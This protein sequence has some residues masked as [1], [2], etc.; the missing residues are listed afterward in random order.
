[1]S[2]IDFDCIVV[3]AG[4]S[5]C[6][7]AAILSQ[8]K[9]V[10]LLEAGE[11]AS[12]ESFIR[13]SSKATSNY[14]GEF[15]R[16]YWQGE[17]LPI[18]ELGNRMMHYTGGRVLGGSSS[19]NGMQ[20]V[21]GTN[22]DMR[23][24]WRDSERVYNVIEEFIPMERIPHEP[25]DANEEICNA[26]SEGTGFPLIYDY[27]DPSTP[28]GV[29]TQWTLT[30]RNGVRASSDSIFLNE[31]NWGNLTLKTSCTVTRVLFRDK[32]AIGV[33]YLDDGRGKVAYAPEIV[34]S[35][36]I[37]SA[38][39]LLLSGIG[40]REL[41][42]EVGVDL[43]YDNPDVG[44][45]LKNHLYFNLKIKGKIGSKDGIFSGGAFLPD[46]TGKRNYQLILSHSS[47][48]EMN[49]MV[50]MTRLLSEGSV[51][52][53]SSDPLSMES[54]DFN[55]MSHEDDSEMVDYFF[56]EYYGGIEK[57]LSKY[58]YELHS[59][60]DLEK[61]IGETYHFTGT[62]SIGKVVNEYGKVYGVDGLSVIDNSIIPVNVDGNTQ[63]CAYLAG[64]ICGHRKLREMLKL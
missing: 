37:K 58:G 12:E 36:G 20:Y 9:K 4:T 39:I 24:A 1:M 55:Y 28:L 23:G 35:A 5:G 13:N 41:L 46:W 60:N 63:A 3:G 64:W 16:L 14:P 7:V 43:V 32:K 26:L 42:E 53:N 59:F 34:L 10:L 47:K 2:I 25:S 54:V 21:R 62:C 57:S 17:S 61:E 18:K 22:F 38:K 31:A 52:L 6:E 56:S 40:D 19:I 8:E 50:I 48:D 27:N 15:S 11:D 29:F 51:K 44:K 49:L 33:T 45:G 30:Q